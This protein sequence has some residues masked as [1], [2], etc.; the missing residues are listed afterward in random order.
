MVFV[1]LYRKIRDVWH[2]KEFVGNFMFIV[3][4]GTWLKLL[5]AVLD[6]RS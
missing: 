1:T 6:Y 5:H 3:V 4:E 2:S